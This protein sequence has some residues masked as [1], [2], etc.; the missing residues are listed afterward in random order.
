MSSSMKREALLEVAERLFY[1]K[2]FRGVGL[3]QII[4]EANVATM[5]LYNHFSSKEKLVEEVL[6]KREK[7]YWSYLDRYVELDSDSPFILA[8][9]AHGR[10]LKEHSLKG[11]M[12]LRAIED[13]AGK[14]NEIESIARNH[15]SKLICYF[16]QLAFKKGKEN[17]QDL[18]NQFTLLLEG[19]TSMAA[20]IGAEEATSHSIA[21][22]RTL[23]QQAS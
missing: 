16:Q 17:Q 11:D 7:R 12:F 2:G 5:T 13:Y 20:L 3:K 22:A 10:W 19:T 14:N 1:E 15:K 23:V 6:K 18:A 9:E 21:I 4:T 8:V